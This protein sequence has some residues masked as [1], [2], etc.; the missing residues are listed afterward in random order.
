MLITVNP[1]LSVEV[2]WGKSTIRKTGS[3]ALAYSALCKG[4]G[5]CSWTMSDM[6]YFQSHNWA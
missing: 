2:F 1:K 3:R 6:F 5:D 4:T